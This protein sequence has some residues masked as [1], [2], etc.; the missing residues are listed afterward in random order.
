MTDLFYPGL[1][2]GSVVDVPDGLDVTSEIVL[3]AVAAMTANPTGAAAIASITQ[4]PV[5]FANGTELVQSI[6]T[7]LVGAAGYPDVLRLTHGHPVFD[8]MTTQ[9]TGALPPATLQL[10]NASVQ[11][12]SASTAGLTYIE[13]NYTPTGNLQMPALTLST[14]RDPVAPG[15]HR[16]A[17]GAAVAAAGDSDWLVQRS[18]PGTGNGYGHCTFTPVE[19]ATAF[20]DL[21]LWAEYGVKPAN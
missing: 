20:L 21:V 5:P 19:L 10:I 3:P 11:R 1:L 9:Y 12:Y 6:V 7:A 14:F 17:Y 4:T 13:H 18:V 15:F 16:S 2:P 8:N